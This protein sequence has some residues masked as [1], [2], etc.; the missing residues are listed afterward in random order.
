MLF[1]QLLDKYTHEIMPIV[2]TPTI[3]EV[4]LRYSQIFMSP[5]FVMSGIRDEFSSSICKNYPIITLE[6]SPTPCLEVLHEVTPPIILREARQPLD[7]VEREAVIQK[8]GVTRSPRIGLHHG[9]VHG[10]IKV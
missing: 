10:H 8:I 4:C 2:Y 5:K 3:G 1:Y 9:H 7:V 6:Q